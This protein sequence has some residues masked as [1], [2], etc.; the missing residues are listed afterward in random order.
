MVV[1]LAQTT[2]IAKYGLKGLSKF[3]HVTLVDTMTCSQ[4]LKLE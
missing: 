1:R 2:A 4:Y 3:D